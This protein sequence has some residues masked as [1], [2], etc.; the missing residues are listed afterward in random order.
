MKSFLKMHCFMLIGLFVAMNAGLQIYM[1]VGYYKE[2]IKWSHVIGEGGTAVIWFVW[3]IMLLRSRPA[4]RIT[5]L[6]SFGMCCVC[7]SMWM[8]MLDEFIKLPPEAA[9]WDILLEKAPMPIGML[10]I[11]LGLYHLHHEQQAISA[12]MSK[13]ERLFREHRLFDKL[14][15]LNGAQYLRQQ[16]RQALEQADA[17]QQPLSVIAI[18]LDDFSQINQV[19]GHDEGDQVLQVVAQVLLFNLRQQDVL[20]R[21]AGD[22]F[23]AVLP[24]TGTSQASEIAQDMRTSIESIAHRTQRH[25]ERLQLRAT[26]VVAMAI[27]ESEEQLLKRLNLLVASAKPRQILGVPHHAA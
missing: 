15:P 24:N 22:R 8:D 5:R 10:L 25:G 17:E 13:R 21:L 3:M 23:V 14:T 7:F 20:C 16:L 1:A 9:I 6:L 18:D 2:V 4:G 27:N 26:A 19:Y 12:Q 11:T